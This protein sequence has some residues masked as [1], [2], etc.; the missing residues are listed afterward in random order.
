MSRVDL[1]PFQSK[2]ERRRQQ[3]LEA[4]YRDI[5]IP[6]VIA[7]LGRG[8]EQPPEKTPALAK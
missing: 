4:Q 3:A 6:E 5:A 2:A 8:K 1:R 7:A